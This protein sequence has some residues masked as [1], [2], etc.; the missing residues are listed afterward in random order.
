MSCKTRIIQ[1]TTG[2]AGGNTIYAAN[3]TLTGNRIVNMGGFDLT[4]N[5]GGTFVID[6]KLT[7]TGLIDPIGLIFTATPPAAVPVTVGQGALLVGDG[8]GGTLA[9]ELYFKTSAGV[10]DLVL[11]KNS[12]SIMVGATAVLNGEIGAVPQPLAGEEGLFLRGDGTWAAGGSD[13]NFAE[14][15]LTATANRSHDWATF[16]Y[17]QSNFS[18]YQLQSVGN[19]FFTINSNITLDASTITLTSPTGS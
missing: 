11:R 3:D 8:T 2:G 10:S 9:D 4:F 17:T 16:N 1:L 13:G 7:V 5:N 18:T 15:D 14:T 19:A 12:S 6:G